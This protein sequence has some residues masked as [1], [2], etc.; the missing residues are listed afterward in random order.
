MK[1]KGVIPA[2]TT[3]FKSGSEIDHAFMTGHCQWLVENGCTGVVVLGSLGEGQGRT[4]WTAN[5][6]RGQS[7]EGRGDR[8]ADVARRF[9][10]SASDGAARAP[11]PGDRRVDTRGQIAPYPGGV[12]SGACSSPTGLRTECD[13]GARYGFGQRL[14]EAHNHRHP[15]LLRF[16]LDERPDRNDLNAIASTSDS[17]CGDGCR[18]RRCYRHNA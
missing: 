6:G 11:V 10:A 18:E 9:R 17:S 7:N 8:D 13:P 14:Y 5:R 4:D 3:C 2:I 12:A 16:L 1:W 15:V